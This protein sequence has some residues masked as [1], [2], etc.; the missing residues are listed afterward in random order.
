MRDLHE[1][2]LTVRIR[3]ANLPKQ[4]PLKRGDLV[5]V[6]PIGFEPTLVMLTR[7][8]LLVRPSKEN[9]SSHRLLTP[10]GRRLDT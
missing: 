3:Y 10:L 7:N 8:A 5:L 4:K 1:R 6:H 9:V 2:T